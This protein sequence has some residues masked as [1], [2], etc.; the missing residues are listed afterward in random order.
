MF[1]KYYTLCVGVL[2]IKYMIYNYIPDCMTL[3]ICQRICTCCVG[4]SDFSCVMS[5]SDKGR[6]NY[7]HEW[8]PLNGILQTYIC[9]LDY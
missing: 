6:Y 8:M 2:I 5:Y 7:P 4:G 1:I 3:Y 9:Y